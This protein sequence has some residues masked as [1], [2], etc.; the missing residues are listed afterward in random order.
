MAFQGNFTCNSFKEALF[1][2]DVDFLVDTIKIALYD[3][4]A[5]LNASTT[6]YTTTGEVVATGYT[7]TGNTLTPSVTLGTDGIAY[8]DFA[9]TSWTAAITARGALIYKSSGT[10]ICVLDFGS[11]KTSV[12]TFTVQFPVNDSS[13]ALIRLN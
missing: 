12:T 4:T 10:A 1:K 7:A 11:D 6:A 2:G 3:N 8:V 9:D 5:T 13:S